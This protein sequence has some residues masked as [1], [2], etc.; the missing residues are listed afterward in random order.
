MLK[1][2]LLKK[3]YREGSSSESL[4]FEHDAKVWVMPEDAV[5]GGMDMY[6]P[7]SR[8]GASI[9]KRKRSLLSELRQYFR[10]CLSKEVFLKKDSLKFLSRSL[11]S[12]WICLWF[13]YVCGEP[14]PD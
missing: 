6:Q 9:K 3:L 7:S 5:E 14:S 10:D 13:S 4:V 8:G 12:A 2:D 11:L 1:N